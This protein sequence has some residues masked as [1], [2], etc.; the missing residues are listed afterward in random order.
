MQ[1]AMRTGKIQSG[2]AGLSR[3]R[4][5]VEAELDMDVDLS[6]IRSGGPFDTPPSMEVPNE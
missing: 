3:V 5:Q 4:R 2:E 6:V 1:W